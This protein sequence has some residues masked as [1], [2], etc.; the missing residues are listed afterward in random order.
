MVLMFVG[1]TCHTGST[2]QTG[3]AQADKKTNFGLVILS[4]GLETNGRD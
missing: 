4:R 2:G 3:P 1:H